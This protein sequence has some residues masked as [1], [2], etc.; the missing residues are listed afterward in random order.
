MPGSGSQGRL[1]FGPHRIT[2]TQDHS[3]KSEEGSCLAI[4]MCVCVCVC[5]YLYIYYI[6]FTYIIYIYI[7]IE[8]ERERE[9]DKPRE[10]SKLSRQRNMFQ[11]K[12]Q[13]KSLEKDVNEWR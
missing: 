10:T 1:C 8:R 2:P 12:E 4:Y 13:G 9:R 5:V 7:Y 3:F 11:T 6:F